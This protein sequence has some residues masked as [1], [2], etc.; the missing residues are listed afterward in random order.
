MHIN[1]K[2]AIVTVILV[3]LVVARLCLPYFVT[4]YV[5]KV[6]ADIEGDE[7]SIEVVYFSLW[8]GAFVIH[9]MK[10]DKVQGEVALPFIDL[11][12]M[13]L[14]VEWEALLDGAIVGTIRLQSP[15]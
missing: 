4:R 7:G 14:S 15:K 10:L 1:K 13:D 6:L 11:P 8:R 3:I 2:W 5:H 12:N 9:H